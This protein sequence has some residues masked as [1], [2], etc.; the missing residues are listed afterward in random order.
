MRIASW[1]VNGLR[2]RIDFVLRWLEDRRPDVVGLQEL[3]L[4]DDQ[5]P[6]ER[7]REAGYESVVVGQKA[8]NGVAVLSRHPLELVEAGLDGQQDLGARFVIARTAGLL[9]ASAYVPNGKAVDHDDFPRKLAWLDRLAE[10]WSERASA[11]APAVLCGDF[12]VCPEPIDSWN[13]EALA[14]TIFHTE[15][16]RQRMRT[17]FAG[18]GIDLFRVQHP[19]EQAFSWWDYRGGAF[20]RGRGLRIDLLLG[21]EAVRK[22]LAGAGIDRDYRKKIGELKPSDHAPV[23]ADLHPEG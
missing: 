8:W 11:A 3:K 13:E 6:H 5:Y 23:W 20:P 1:N 21:S 7:L 17:L 16:E 2:A 15:A 9:F 4:T 10:V 18:G 22:R 19:D 14:G 12:N